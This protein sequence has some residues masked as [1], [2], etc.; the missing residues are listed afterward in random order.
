MARV[1]G[2]HPGILCTIM[3]RRSHQLKLPLLGHSRAVN[4]P[5][6]STSYPATC[7]VVRAGQ[8]DLLVDFA[9]M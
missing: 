3:M 9:V 2:N 6:P 8:L 7:A 1:Y 5:N 4:M